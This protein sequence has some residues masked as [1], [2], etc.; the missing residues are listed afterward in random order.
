MK[1]HACGSDCGDGQKF[2]G[3]CG[4]RLSP[5]PTA[6]RTP[7]AYTPQHLTERI[8]TSRSALEGERKQVTVLFCD[9]ANSTPLA[10]R[11][12]PEQMHKLLNAF[13]DIALQQVHRLEGT[14]N[15]FLGDGFMALFGA[16][17][18][19]EDHA[20]RAVL[21][22]IGIRDEIRAHSFAD[23]GSDARLQ[24]RIG[25]N[26]GTVVVGKIGDNLR[27]DYTAI[28]DTTNV[29]ARLQGI[30]Q[31]GTVLVTDAVYR[32]VRRDIDCRSLGPQTLKGKDQPI[33]VYEAIAAISRRDHVG[34]EESRST[35]VGRDGELASIRDAI[36]ALTSG[37]GAI[38]T[39]TGDAG[40]GKSR[41]LHESMTLLRQSP[42]LI[43]EGTAVSHGRTD[44]YRPFR[45][46]LGMLLGIDFGRPAEEAWPL[47]ARRVGVLTGEADPDYLPWVATLL[48][49]KLPPA[50]AA[51]VA[52]IDS[53]AVG[54]QI[55]RG[56]RQFLLSAARRHPIALM[57]DDWHWTDDSSSALLEHIG[58]ICTEAPLLI[59]VG[60][61]PYD[62]GPAARLMQFINDEAKDS[63]R[64]I[65]LQ[66]LQTDACSALTSQ[67]LGGGRIAPRLLSALAER[68]SGNPF[69][70]SELVHALREQAAIRADSG[71]SEWTLADG[72]MSLPLPGSLEGIILARVDRL[73]DDCKQALKAASVVGRSFTLG[74][75]R[76]VLA[77]ANDQLAMVDAALNAK[78]L[79]ETHS[80]GQPG[81]AF[82]HPVIQ[83][84]VYGSIVADQRVTLHRQVAEAIEFVHADRLEPHYA[85]LAYHY[86]RAEE[87]PR[88]IDYLFK[89]GEVAGQVAA[90][91]EA[92]DHYRNALQLL[93]TAADGRVDSLQRS[94]LEKKIGEVL[95]QLGRHDEA[96]E[97]LRRALGHLG[98]WSP[99]LLRDTR[100]AVLI[101]GARL[102]L[103]T[104][105][106]RRAR[107]ATAETVDD[108]I[109]DRICAILVARC[110]IDYF[111]HTM[112]WLVDVM[113][114]ARIAS[115]GSKLRF[116]AISLAF[117]SVYF[118]GVGWLRRADALTRRSLKF[119]HAAGEPFA[120]GMSQ[121]FRSLYLFHAGRLD[122]A[123][124]QAVESVQQLWIARDIRCWAWA[125]GTHGWIDSERGGLDWLQNG[126]R[127]LDVATDTRDSEAA[128]LGM[129]F[130]GVAR[131]STGDFDEVDSLLSQAVRGFEEIPDHPIQ[132]TALGFWAQSLIDAG[133]W[134]DALPLCDRADRLIR[135]H[136]IQGAWVT[137]ALLARVRA[138]LAAAESNRGAAAESLARARSALRAARRQAR[139]TRDFGASETLRLSALL[140]FLS[141]RRKQSERLWEE[142][143]SIGATIGARRSVAMSHYDRGRLTDRRN[144]IEWAMQSFERIGAS[145]RVEECRAMLR[146]D[147]DK[148]A[149]DDV[150]G[151]ECEQQGA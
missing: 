129:L 96:A 95:F 52:A 57:L 31:P 142:A 130:K 132:V 18:T 30:A 56:I 87:W 67:L 36:A 84:A 66:P 41:L 137:N 97:H 105:S 9:I 92:L 86:G 33:E 144:D 135:E 40:A 146:Q 4:A 62:D 27:M 79:I 134:S 111:R 85:T 45:E 39:I 70:L 89:A 141:G 22:A 14:V 59:L 43:G 16:P 64:V 34:A 81:L 54:R 13:F 110:S 124:E 122:E 90:D 6:E 115:A 150:T 131:Y 68:S 71:G 104:I 8:L 94:D 42:V 101:E 24:I 82:R 80:E 65:A 140:E 11:L 143:I 99:R 15:Q 1:C 5:A 149:A 120:L 151:D 48:G 91:A 20:R 26:T 148:G 12:G 55:F 17:L 25:M 77:A 136:M 44:G 78:L 69:Y 133:R 118:E 147:R 121:L 98:I 114:L 123:A 127:L 3:E 21:A 10:A 19:Q 76:R 28:G 37:R 108:P 117:A 119:G 138:H 73:A 116:R 60:T 113:M 75:L 47:L 145:A 128:A 102:L 38:V 107:E 58:Q 88:T 2:C 106:W 32:M 53:L 126:Q 72:V 49:L 139:R 63:S 29:A 74:L 112:F 103:R 23:G 35:L 93:D 7:H 109:R 125:M 50:A 46:A 61:R 51:E 83:Q 100:Q